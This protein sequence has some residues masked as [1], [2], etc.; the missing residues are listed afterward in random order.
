[1]A[2]KKRSVAPIRRPWSASRENFIQTQLR[3]KKIHPIDGKRKHGLGCAKLRAQFRVRTWGIGD[4]F[5]A[6]VFRFSRR[7]QRVREPVRAVPPK[8]ETGGT[9]CCLWLADLAQSN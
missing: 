9:F 5:G 2:L 1:M 6:V 8:L 4:P 7:R 3:F